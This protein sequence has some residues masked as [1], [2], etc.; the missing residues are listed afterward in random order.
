[1]F[2]GPNGAGKST[3]ADRFVRERIPIVNPDNIARDLP[4]TADGGLAELAAG[5]LALKERAERMRLGETFA[6]ETTLSGSRAEGDA[7]RQGGGLQGQPH[8]C[9]RI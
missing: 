5:K 9:R 1:M 7:G 3:L 2:A 6:F 4:R 8:L